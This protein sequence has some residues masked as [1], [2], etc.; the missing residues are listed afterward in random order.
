MAKVDNNEEVKGH[1]HTWHPSH[2]LSEGRCECGAIMISIVEKLRRKAEWD[3]YYELVRT[4]PPYQMWV[5]LKNGVSAEELKR[6][7]EEQAQRVIITKDEFGDNVYVFK[8]SMY[9]KKPHFP[10]PE[11]F[12]YE[13]S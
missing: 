7:K 1:N 9:L 6:L 12:R 4:T 11:R 2:D 3:N 8:D 10:D 13:V 5:A